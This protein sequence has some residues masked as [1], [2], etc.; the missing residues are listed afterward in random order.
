MSVETNPSTQSTLI[1]MS[2]IMGFMHIVS[3]REDLFMSR[4]YVRL[5]RPSHVHVSQF[6]GACRFLQLSSHISLL[7]AVISVLSVRYIT[8]KL[9]LNCWCVFYST[10]KNNP[11]GYI[12]L[13]SENVFVLIP[14]NRYSGSS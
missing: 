1:M 14:Q 10:C 12:L 5:S 9:K 6:S 11:R 13:I 3:L 2:P 7:Y 4:N 8:L